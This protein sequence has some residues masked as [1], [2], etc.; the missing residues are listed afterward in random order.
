MF[1]IFTVIV[2]DIPGSV[3]PPTLK[4][5]YFFNLIHLKI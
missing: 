3:Y 2:F 5:A 1:N 4:E